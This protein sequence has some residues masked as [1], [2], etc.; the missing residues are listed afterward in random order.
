VFSFSLD[1]AKKKANGFSMG[2]RS[3]RERYV[4]VDGKAQKAVDKAIK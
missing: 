4:L 3:E 2:A 1:L